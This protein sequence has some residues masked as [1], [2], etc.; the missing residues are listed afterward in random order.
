LK[1]YRYTSKERDRENGFTYH[2]AR[3]YA[4]W[5]GRWTAVDP[6]A[7]K[8]IDLTPYRYGGNNPIGFVG[9]TGLDDEQ[10][11][12]VT[13]PPPSPPPDPNDPDEIKRKTEAEE[14]EKKTTEHIV[15][16]GSAANPSGGT[17]GSGAFQAE[18]VVVPKVQLDSNE[19]PPQTDEA[20]V[21]VCRW[22]PVSSV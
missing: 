13:L 9:T 4:P 14:H 12:G 8:S 3:Y 6:A 19:A 22:S 7:A 11:I 2:G 16:A 21:R 10:P 20:W 15:T 1:R 5:L 18:A 17:T